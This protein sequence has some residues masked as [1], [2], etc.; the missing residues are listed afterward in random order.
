MLFCYVWFS[1]GKS[2]HV[3][4]QL[5]LYETVGFNAR[6]SL[7]IRKSLVW[8]S[9]FFLNFK[10]DKSEKLKCWISKFCGITYSNSDWINARNL[11]KIAE[12][13]IGTK[14]NN[15]LWLPLYCIK[16]KT[17]KIKLRNWACLRIWVLNEKTIEQKYIYLTK[18]ALKPNTV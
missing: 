10:W 8:F 2:S 1:F 5:F 15:N 6:A 7:R 9:D 11:T 17:K 3:N 18:K 13:G 12:S 4:P 16:F 14:R